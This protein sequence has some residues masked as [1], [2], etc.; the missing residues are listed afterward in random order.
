MDSPF[1]R[2][3]FGQLIRLKAGLL[4]YYSVSVTITITINIASYI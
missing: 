2:N 4:N 1:L 3:Y